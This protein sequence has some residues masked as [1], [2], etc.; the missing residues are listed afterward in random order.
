MG[1]Q[2]AFHSW[3]LMLSNCSS[4]Y[5]PFV[6]HFWRN[7]YLNYLPILKMGLFT[8]KCECAYCHWSIHLKTGWL[9]MC[10][11]YFT[12]ITN[13]KKM[14]KNC[15]CVIFPFIFFFKRPYDIDKSMGLLAPLCVRQN[16]GPPKVSHSN[17]RKL[18]ICY[19]TGRGTFGSDW[20]KKLEMGRLSWI[21]QW[22]PAIT[23]V[24]IRGRQEAQ[25]ERR[26]DNKAEVGGNDAFWRWGKGHIPGNAGGF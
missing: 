14:E 10:C 13:N 2:F 12:T 15:G 5:Q 8:K 26:Y 11:V 24:L 18:W 7:I 21:I 20:V 23:R 22:V 4:A 16:N 25:D 1:V 6:N 17:P 9:V 3:L 19:C